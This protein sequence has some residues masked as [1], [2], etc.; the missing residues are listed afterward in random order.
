[1]TER[2]VHTKYIEDDTGAV[3]IL[4]PLSGEYQDRFIVVYESA[5]GDLETNVLS[6]KALINNYGFT[7]EEMVDVKTLLS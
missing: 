5:F 4:K 3:T 2:V 6:E 1:M 7:K